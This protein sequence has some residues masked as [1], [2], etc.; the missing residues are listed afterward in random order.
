MSSGRW[1]ARIWP[2]WTRSPIETLTSTSSPGFLKL[3]GTLVGLAIGPVAATVLRR[4]P[5]VTWEDW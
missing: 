5:W 2:G 1:R 3:T 4:V